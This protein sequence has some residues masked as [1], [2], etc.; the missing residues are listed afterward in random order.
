MPKNQDPLDESVIQL[1]E[2]WID[3]GAVG[4]ILGCTDPEACNYDESA[5]SDDGSCIYND[6]LGELYFGFDK[7]LTFE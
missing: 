7:Y 6:C 1:I 2:N 5:N 4:S 3:E